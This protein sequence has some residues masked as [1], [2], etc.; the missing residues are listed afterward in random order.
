MRQHKAGPE[1]REAQVTELA[2][3]GQVLGPKALV[4]CWDSRSSYFYQ[5]LGSSIHSLLTGREYVHSLH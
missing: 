1:S 5:H 2:N 3:A 4:L